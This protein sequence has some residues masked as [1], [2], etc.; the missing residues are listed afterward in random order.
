MTDLNIS[1]IFP[2]LPSPK[3]TPMM[4]NQPPKYQF[5]RL[6]FTMG[7]HETYQ[8]DQTDLASTIRDPDATSSA[9]TVHHIEAHQSCI[10]WHWMQK[11]SNV[12][13][14]IISLTRKNTRNK[15]NLAKKGKNKKIDNWSTYL[16][17]WL[18]ALFW[19][20]PQRQ[21]QHLLR[22]ETRVMRENMNY[23]VIHMQSITLK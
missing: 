13:L 1:R 8:D 22:L 19:P 7:W 17:L 16:I 18:H 11:L 23:S 5:S 20:R 10:T 2:T 14:T 15:F 12:D 21:H 9:T 4:Q 3:V 6:N